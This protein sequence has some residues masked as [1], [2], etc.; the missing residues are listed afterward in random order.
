MASKHGAVDARAN[1]EKYHSADPRR[2]SRRDHRWFDPDRIIGKTHWKDRHVASAA[3]AIAPSVLVT[4][5]LK[6]FDFAEL[7][8]LDVAVQT[9]D[10]FL[11]DLFD[12]NPALVEAATREAHDNL[13]RSAPTSV[14]YLTALAD[15]NRLP[16]FVERLRSWRPEDVE[17]PAAPRGLG[18]R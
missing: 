13:K 4:E 17:Q 3:A 12:A 16:K 2:I 1:S 18:R 9:P 10:D 6:D 5:N 15:R 8:A 7:A 11:A 14:E